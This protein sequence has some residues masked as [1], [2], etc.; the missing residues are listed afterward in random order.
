M[1]NNP[2][3]GVQLENRAGIEALSN[4]E[5]RQLVFKHGWLL[6]RGAHYDA[7]DFEALATRLGE[8]VQYGFGKVLNMEAQKDA[9]ESQFSNASMPLHQDTILNADNNA[10]FLVFRCLETTADA[11]GETLLT[12]NRRFM[13]RIPADLLD[14]LRNVEFSY[15]PL[16]SGYYKLRE[17]ETDIRLPPL[18]RHPETGEEIP[19]L[20]LDDPED[21]RRNYAASV[22]A[23]DAN[24]SRSLMER[25]DKALRA[26]D[27]L[28]AHKWQVGDLLI[29]DNF[30]VCHGRNPSSYGS[31]RRLERIAL[32]ARNILANA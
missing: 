16:T 30:L 13:K 8:H 9:A 3:F 27:I 15:R 17:N 23:Y 22:V 14:I 7:P 31:R 28:Y 2:T 19:Y 11:G 6:I 32:K 24:A 25:I 20:A 29:I 10:Q 12:D 18:A 5:L 4:E 21:E 1:E 26:P